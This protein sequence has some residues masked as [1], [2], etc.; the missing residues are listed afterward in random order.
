MPEIRNF[1]YG[2][3]ESEKA[4][5][6]VRVAVFLEAVEIFFGHYGSPPIEK[7]GPYAY[8]SFPS[9]LPL[10]PF[11]FFSVPFFAPFWGPSP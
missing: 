2:W 1:Y 10:F 5:L 4:I 9:P 8:A 3:G 6:Q 11:Y 7:I